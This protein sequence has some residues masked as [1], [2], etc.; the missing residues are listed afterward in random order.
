MPSS[1]VSERRRA[2]TGASRRPSPGTSHE[3]PGA[4]RAELAEQLAEAEDRYKRALADLDNYRKRTVR[5]I[6]RRVA[7]EPRGAPARLARGGRQRRA[8]AAA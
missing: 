5:E 1:R 4:R 6:E 8:R 2:S 3:Q 7:G